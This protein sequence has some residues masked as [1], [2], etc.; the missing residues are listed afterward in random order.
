VNKDAH[1]PTQWRAAVIPRPRMP[2]RRRAIAALTAA[3]VVLTVGSVSAAA[4]P[5]RSAQPS[6]AKPTVVL[7]H[8]AWADSGSWDGVVGRLVHDGYPVHAFATPLLSLPGDATAL[9]TY[10]DTLPGPIVL[11][12]HSYGG[13]VIT[14]AATGD[15]HVK[16][17]V[18]LDAFAPN[19]GQAV[20]SLAG[21]TSAI[22][23]PAAF[24]LVPAGAPT[25]QTE[26][27]VRTDVFVRSVANDVSR[28]RARVLAATQRPITLQALTGTAGTPAWATIPSWYEVGT[29]DKIITPDSQR[30]MAR[31]AHAH[32]STARTGHLP[33]VSDPGAVTATIRRAA[34][35][36]A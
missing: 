6:I 18:Y 28:K 33:M 20:S 7:V 26:F 2:R 4:V 35:A 13:A 24:S 21:A 11:V 15:T 5:N 34:R 22:A 25:L 32:I 36:T 10:L 12:G 14:E 23:D 1:R 31:A 8:G 3:G 19:R 9:R 16:A 27:Y 29:I 30:A 17:L